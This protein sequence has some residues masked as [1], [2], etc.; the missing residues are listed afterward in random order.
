[1]SY[2]NFISAALNDK[3]VLESAQFIRDALTVKGAELIKSIQA[4]MYGGVYE[5]HDDEDD[6]KEN[7]TEKK[8]K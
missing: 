4:Q 8:D 3:N 1:M 7:E 6:E 5:E 2:A